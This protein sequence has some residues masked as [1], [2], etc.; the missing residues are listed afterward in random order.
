MFGP[1]ML[2]LMADMT[3]VRAAIAANGVA[4]TACALFFHLTARELRPQPD[5]AP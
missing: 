1:A 5:P 3:S 4:L 2:G